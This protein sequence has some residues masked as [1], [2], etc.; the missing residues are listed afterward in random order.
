VVGYVVIVFYDI[1]SIDLLVARQRPGQ[2]NHDHEALTR[3][4]GSLTLVRIAVALVGPVVPRPVR[5]LLGQAVGT[6]G[7][8]YKAPLLGF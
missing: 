7:R 8:W 1:D 3:V 2:P 5:S 6:A 4:A